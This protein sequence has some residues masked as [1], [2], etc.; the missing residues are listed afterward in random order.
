[1]PLGYDPV[2]KLPSITITFAHVS[3]TLLMISY[4]RYLHGDSPAMH[5]YVGMGIWVLATIFYLMR[6]ITKAKLDLQEKSFELSNGEDSDDSH[7]HKHEHR[8]DE[9]DESN[10]AHDDKCPTPDDPDAQ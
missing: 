3:F 6:K 1:M 4:L 9:R 8:D 5:V 2:S 7:T 10:D